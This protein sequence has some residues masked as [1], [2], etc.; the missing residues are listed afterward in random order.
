MGYDLFAVSLQ[1][2]PALSTGYNSCSYWPNELAAM[3]KG[4]AA[5]FNEA[6][7][8]CWIHYSDNVPWGSS[9]WHGQVISSVCQDRVADSIGHI[10]SMHYDGDD[11]CFEGFRA[12]AA[13][14]DTYRTVNK[15]K[16]SRMWNTEWGGFRDLWNDTATGSTAPAGAWT[17]ARNLFRALSYD[18]NAVTYWA[19]GDDPHANPDDDSYSLY[20]RV[21]GHIRKGPLFYVAKN[22][23]RY[24]RPG[25]VRIGCSSND[26]ARVKA[27][28]FTHEQQQTKTIVLLNLS[29]TQQSATIAGSGLPASMTIYQ[30]SPTQNCATMGT[31]GPGGAV[32][33][34]PRSVTTLH[35]APITNVELREN[36]AAT[37]TAGA[38]SY[39]ALD[40]RLLKGLG[41]EVGVGA[42]DLPAG[43]FVSK[44][45]QR[46]RVSIVTGGR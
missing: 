29:A 26:T 7:L 32:T 35:S 19:L 41:S 30:T 20:Y 9:D 24:I 23:Y 12:Q 21:N 3:I 16:K 37:R 18:F 22:Y 15:G 14:T 8:P 42:G 31:V 4:V 43:A 13:G 1:N 45:R 44:M 40:G 6:R 33:L 5:K 28:A 10:M 38:A 11:G 36:Q 46:G 2:E 39:Y 34:P 25:A 27:I 17:C